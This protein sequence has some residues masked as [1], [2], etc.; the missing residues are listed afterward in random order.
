[1]RGLFRGRAVGLGLPSRPGDLRRVR[2]LLSEARLFLNLRKW[3]FVMFNCSII[4]WATRG[5]ARLAANWI[6]SLQALGVEDCATVYCAS[7]AC[8]DVLSK[9]V[10]VTDSAATIELAPLG[11]GR[12]SGGAVSAKWGTT[13]FSDLM[14]SKL[15]LLFAR[16]VSNAPFL[17]VDSDCAFCAD[18]FEGEHGL[19][20]LLTFERPT[21][22][23]QGDRADDREPGPES[24]TLCAGVI[25]CPGRGS[26]SVFQVA[27][28]YLVRE[29]NRPG[30]RE[31][32]IGDQ[33]CI[34]EA[35]R[36]LCHSWSILPLT[37][38]VNGAQ[39][40]NLIARERANDSP[41]LVHANWIV[42]VPS[43]EQRLR[44]EGAWFVRDDHLA[45][46]GL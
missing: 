4:S 45:E 34:N 22:Y 12:N 19:G 46:S 24:N 27:K 15:D 44:A 23:F 41:I 10:K 28:A 29:L 43:K 37:H 18:P 5:H 30:V 17:Y 38:W 7:E 32:F 3:G 16:A 39:S 26:E 13:D 2:R 1:M 11:A 35:I 8:A 33:E 21:L 14:L 40:W 9:F 6:A 25:Y 20:E 42:G 36:F 31:S